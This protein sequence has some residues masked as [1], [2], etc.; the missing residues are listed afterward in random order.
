MPIVKQATIRKKKNENKKI[1]HNI[2]RKYVYMYIFI[3]YF[4]TNY[5][6]IITYPKGHAFL[7]LLHES[8][9]DL[10]H[11]TYSNHPS[12]FCKRVNELCPSTHAISSVNKM[13]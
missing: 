11:Q 8:S 12:H 9:N 7:F 2:S 10:Y 5:Q 4:L 1:N 6:I 3:K 13:F